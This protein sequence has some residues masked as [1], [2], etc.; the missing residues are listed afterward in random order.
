MRFRM[1]A[2]LALGVLLGSALPQQARGQEGTRAPVPHDQVIS[3]NPLLLLFEWFNAEYERKISNTSTAGIGGGW[4]SLDGGD[5]DYV[6]VHG[7]Y[8]YYPQG[9][10]LSGFY[11]GGKLGVHRVETSGA[12]EDGTALGF[13]ID[14]GYN[15]LLGVNR[16]FYVSI[17][18]G[19]NR[20]FGLDLEDASATLPTLRLVN[21]GFAF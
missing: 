17:G 12:D 9:A 1:T 11:F 2:L 4:I 13:G 8:R 6:N 10:A 5:D 20:L 18:I 19:A 14:V 21:I 16:A 7:F 3:A 15:W